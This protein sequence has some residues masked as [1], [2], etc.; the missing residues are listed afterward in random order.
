MPLD[1]QVETLLAQ[2]A[3]NTGPTLE[4][5]TPEQARMMTDAFFPIAS[6]PGDQSVT[7]A[8]RT[9]P[10]PGGVELP[11][12]I[13]TPAGDAPAGG[14]PL[15]TYLHGGGWV[16]GS[17]ATHDA[18]CRDLAADTDAV[19]V[20]IGYRMAPEASFPQPVE[21]CYAG[22]Q[23]VA[24]EGASLGGDPS[25]LAIAGDS[26]GGNLAAVVARVAKDRGGPALRFQLL[27]YP[28]TDCTRSSASYAEN[29]EGRFL[30]A[31][32]MH[33][34]VEQY[35]GTGGDP[36]D[37]L[38]SPL[39]ASDEDLAGLPPAHVITAEYDPLRDEGEAY[40][41]KLRAAGVP[42]TSRRYDGQ[43]HGCFGMQAVVD[44]SRDIIRDAAAALQ[45]GLA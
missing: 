4:Q 43:I 16:I 9:I 34:F 35:L 6:G 20:S 18:T 42:V 30:T 25:R 3:A 31:S 37:P 21:D 41:E 2:S 33:W 10:G 26:A 1:P 5:M 11:I 40:A 7:T 14:R 32:Q 22:L 8:D 17:I 15:V 27:V 28:V 23:W 13:Y 19:V 12:R 45:A 29:G 39:H 24:S 44:A 38:A 36:K